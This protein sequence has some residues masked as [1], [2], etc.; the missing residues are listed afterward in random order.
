MVSP[1]G[2]ISPNEIKNTIAKA[3]LIAFLIAIRFAISKII[4]KARSKVFR[5]GASPDTS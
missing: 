1:I 3:V 5:K 2:R 4:P